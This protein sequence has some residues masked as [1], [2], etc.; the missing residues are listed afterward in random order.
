MILLQTNRR[1]VEHDQTAA[2]LEITLQ[3]HPPP[4]RP[5]P[6]LLGIHDDDIRRREL[7]IGGQFRAARG[8]DAAF[9]EQCRPFFGKTSVRVNFLPAIGRA[10]ADKNAQRRS[11]RR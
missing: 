11:G 4:R 3:S 2:A 10:A 9:G 8:R 1:R 6:A 7:F 5:S